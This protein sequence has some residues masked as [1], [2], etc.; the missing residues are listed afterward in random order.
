MLFLLNL[1]FYLSQL[2]IFLLW[3]LLWFLWFCTEILKLLF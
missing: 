2:F 1:K 3:L